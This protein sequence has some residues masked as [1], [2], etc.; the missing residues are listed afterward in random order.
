MLDIKLIRSEP[1]KVKA[2]FHKR[3]MDLDAVVDGILARDEERRAQITAL[4]A[5]KAEQNAAKEA[6]ERR[7]NIVF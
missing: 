4:D 2:G 3:E 1:E 5:L 6:L 7:G